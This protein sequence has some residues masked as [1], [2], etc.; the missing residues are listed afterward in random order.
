MGWKLIEFAIALSRVDL[1]TAHPLTSLTT[2][3]A[4]K[5]I[6]YIII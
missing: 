4:L 6:E 3:V 5:R 2:L 1:R